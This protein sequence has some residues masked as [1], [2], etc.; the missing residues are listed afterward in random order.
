MRTWLP[1]VSQAT[2]PERA[3]EARHEW[4]SEDRRHR[5]VRALTGRADCCRPPPRVRA[6]SNLSSDF[7]NSILSGV[8][9]PPGRL[10]NPQS[11][12]ARILCFNGAALPQNFQIP[13][14]GFIGNLVL[15]T[16][17]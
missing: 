3:R 10:Q 5:A 9:C 4:T 6:N 11:F 16:E 7:V 2:R 12:R 1:W 8:K 14:N 15:E 17:L 13:R